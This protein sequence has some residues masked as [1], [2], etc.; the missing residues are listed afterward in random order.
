MIDSKITA[1]SRI[2]DSYGNPITYPFQVSSVVN[3][4]ITLIDSPTTTVTYIGDAV[5][6][7][8]ETDSAWAITRVTEATITSVLLSPN[9]GIYGDKWSER[10]SLT[11]S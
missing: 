5:K 1:R 4:L 6:G 9:Y 7:S 2:Y 11:Y 3:N 8:S 10:A